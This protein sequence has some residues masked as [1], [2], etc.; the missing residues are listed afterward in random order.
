M[1]FEELKKRRWTL[2]VG[3][4]HREERDWVGLN[5]CTYDTHKRFLCFETQVKGKKFAIYYYEHIREG[6]CLIPRPAC[7]FD[8]KVDVIDYEVIDWVEKQFTP[9]GFKALY[10]T[11]FDTLKNF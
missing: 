3:G 8:E 11:I 2:T 5:G 4:N 1:K 10:D 6:R 7:F 9:N